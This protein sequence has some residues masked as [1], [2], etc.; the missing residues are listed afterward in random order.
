MSKTDAVHTLINLVKSLLSKAEQM[1]NN[2]SSQFTF[3][4][5]LSDN[6]FKRIGAGSFSSVWA[7]SKSDFIVKVGSD[8][9]YSRFASRIWKTTNK[10]LPKIYYKKNLNYYDVYIIERLEGKDIMAKHALIYR[11]NKYFDDIDYDPPKRAKRVKLNFKNY[12]NIISILN[13]LS[14]EVT[15]DI[16]KGNVMCRNGRTPVLTDPV[17]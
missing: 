2:D 8:S 4:K 11:L 10:Y 12:R 16:H 15:L 6:G 1:T 5:L 3:Q 14:H 13:S 7:K 17:C 9:A